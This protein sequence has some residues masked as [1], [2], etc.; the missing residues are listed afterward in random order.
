MLL[1]LIWPIAQTTGPD[2]WDRLLGPQ[3]V[4]VIGIIISGILFREW[5]ASILREIT[6]RD[7]RIVDLTKERDVAIDGWRAQTAATNR[8]ADTLELDRAD[9][10]A[11]SRRSD[12]T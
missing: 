3:G 9:R 5:R 4:A 8:V 2:L 6:S 7:A 1:L 12:P 11:R 10:A